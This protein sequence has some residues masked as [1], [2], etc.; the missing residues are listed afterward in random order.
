VGPDRSSALWSHRRVTPARRLGS[1]HDGDEEAIPCHFCAAT[2]QAARL[3]QRS[4]RAAGDV[5]EGS[6]IRGRDALKRRCK[7]VASTGTSDG[8]SLGEGP[9]P[10]NAS[11]SKGGL[12]K[13]RVH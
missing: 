11:L 8:S 7:E 12:S 4:R 3:L 6:A 2:W 9:S 5:T 13:G 10:H 1:G